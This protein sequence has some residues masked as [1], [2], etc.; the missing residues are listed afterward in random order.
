M[1]AGG[2][3]FTYATAH[4]TRSEAAIRIPGLPYLRTA[5][6]ADGLPA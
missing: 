1:P 5:I 4:D 6:F 3:F 2:R